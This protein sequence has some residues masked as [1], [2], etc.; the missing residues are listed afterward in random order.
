MSRGK[1]HEYLG[2][3]LDSSKKGKVIVNMTQ[4]AKGTHKMFPEELTGQV[5]TPEGG[6][7]FDVSPRT[8]LH[9]HLCV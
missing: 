4:Y 2:M 5:N 9:V 1:K 3:T 8:F 7:L 6:H